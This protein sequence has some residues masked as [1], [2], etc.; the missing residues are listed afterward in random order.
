MPSTV[1][2]TRAA[3][4]AAAAASASLSSV[5]PTNDLVSWVI[6]GVLL[7]YAAFVAGSLPPNVAVLFDNIVVRLVLVVLILALGTCD[8]ASAILLTIGFVLSIQTANK[9][10]I[11]K[12]ANRAATSGRRE[13]FSDSADAVVPSA[14]G[15]AGSSLV[16]THTTTPTT[17]EENS[18]TVS[19]S[20]HDAMQAVLDVVAPSSDT[21]PHSHTATTLS[22]S[23]MFTSPEQLAAMQT[24]VVADNQGTEVRTWQD[25]LGPQGLQ[26]PAGFSFGCGTSAQFEPVLT[27]QSH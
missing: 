16:P 1:T 2:T 19:S 26:Q 20:V 15:D 9:L 10:H 12:I 4:A 22:P 17:D 23:K 14:A 13:D 8:P 27:S 6:R 25:E 21:P 18:E 24:N 11:G 7:I 3:S 5:C